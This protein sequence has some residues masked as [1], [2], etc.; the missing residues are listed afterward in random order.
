MLLVKL[1]LS[2]VTGCSCLPLGARDK[3][4]NTGKESKRVCHVIFFLRQFTEGVFFHC[5]RY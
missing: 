5:S 4:L 3:E 2:H 1:T